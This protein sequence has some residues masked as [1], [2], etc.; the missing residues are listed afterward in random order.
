MMRKS[1]LMLRSSAN[2]SC[3]VLLGPAALRLHPTV[4]H[5]QSRHTAT[6]TFRMNVD[7]QVKLTKVPDPP[8]IVGSLGGW[9]QQCYAARTAFFLPARVSA[10]V[11][12]V[13]KPALNRLREVWS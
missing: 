13:E 1:P 8:P 4:S 12:A 9:A 3:R 6:K 2:D 5:A 7:R 10:R 11:I